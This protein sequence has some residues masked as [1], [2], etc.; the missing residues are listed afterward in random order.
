MP[1]ASLIKLMHEGIKTSLYSQTGAGEFTTLINS[2]I[3]DT[4]GPEDKVMPYA[5]WTMIGSDVDVHFDSKE[6]ITTQILVQVYTDYKA[7][8]SNHLTFL[9]ALAAF[10]KFRGNNISMVLKSIGEITLEDRQLVSD[11]LFEAVIERES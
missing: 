6:R 4:V 11:T 5:I 3:Y 7:G 2:R 1:T 8:V 9:D 10:R